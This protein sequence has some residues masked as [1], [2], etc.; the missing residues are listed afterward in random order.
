MLFRFDTV[1]K[2]YGAHTILEDATFQINPGE[3]VGLVGRNGAGKTTLFK[4]LLGV[5]DPDSGQI[6]RIRGLRIGL[7]EQ[8]VGIER[9]GT[10]REATLEVFSDLADMETEMR[11]LEHEMASVAGD[12]LDT[13][14]E[15]YSDL[16]HRFEERDGF[17]AHA[18]AESVLLGLGFT[19]DDFDLQAATLSGGQRARLALA[20]LL[21]EEPDILLLDEPT[22]HLD[23][24]AVE[25]LEE[26]LAA[27]RSAYVIIS[28][29]RFL[30]DR[31]A[32]RIIAVELG[33][34]AS[35]NGNY[36]AYLVERDERRL[37]AEKRYREQMEL[38]ERTEEFI[39]RNIA[40]QKTKQA[41]SR[42][43]LLEKMDRAERPVTDRSQARFGFGAASRTGREVLVTD[44]LA[45]GFPGVTLAAGLNVTV[46]RGDRLG[47]VGGNGTGKT[48]LFKT[49]LGD[50][51]PVA[52]EFVWGHN[53]STGYYDQHLSDLDPTHEVIEEMRIAM[54][55]A[56][57]PALRSY[58][59]RFLFSGDDVFKRVASLSGGERSR[60][61]LAKLIAGG[62]NTLMLD[63]PTNHL[64]IPAREALEESLEE[65]PGTLLVISHDRYFLDR[66]C[67]RLVSIEDG[68]TEVFEGS[69]SE[70]A[71]L[72]AQRRAS[73]R[74]TQRAGKLAD[75]AADEAKPAAA[76]PK[77][78]ST[79]PISDIETDIA[80]I[81]AEIADIDTA[82]ARREIASDHLKLA[83]LIEARAHASERLERFLAE[84]EDASAQ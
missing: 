36:S 20:R 1:K 25:W 35:Y 2:A 70:W 9:T 8:Q 17:S 45:I 47:I 60:L 39:R 73:E 55:G 48:T 66:I 33:K 53:V 49:L 71:D 3:H 75:R 4:L 51:P 63:E 15:T 76:K 6:D 26:F 7:L 77:R 31:T 56:D 62:K 57:D 30:L 19:R 41:K 82:M 22:N 44:E 84:W 50:V 78:T 74:E 43:K 68:R 67:N 18:R 80:E 21:L 40:G 37:L 27:Y 79:R 13:I 64:D 42:R 58:L 59:A 69:Y 32:N 46:E 12:E 29:D 81:E 34:T 72:V 52:G 61:S 28:H 54:P 38:I 23:I 14:L 65:F 10:V 11:R 24:K 5:E 16:Q 83:P